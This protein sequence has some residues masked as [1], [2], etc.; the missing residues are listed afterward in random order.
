MTAAPER[1]RVRV[2]PVQEF[3]FQSDTREILANAARDIDTYDLRNRLIVDIDSHHE[4]SLE[5][6][7]V[8]DNLDDQVL[9]DY[10]KGI[11]GSVPGGAEFALTSHAPG[12][13][14]QEIGGRIP[15]SAE[16]NEPVPSGSEHTVAV[17]E[18]A[19]ESLGLDYQV[20]FPQT[21]L[22]L[23]LHPVDGIAVAL[24]MAYNKWFVGTV[25]G[26]DPRI[27]SMLSLPISDPD[28][29][30][31]TIRLYHDHPDVLGFLITSQRSFGVHDNQNMPVYAELE[32]V[33]LPLGFHAG[34]NWGDSW[35]RTMN[36][37]TTVHAMS[38]VTCNMAHLSN[39]LFNGL[40]ER[41]PRLKVIWIESGLAW[42]PFLMQRLDHEFLL[43]TSD[44]PLLTKRPS[45]YMRQMYYTSQPLEVS[46]PKALAQTL[47]MIDAGNTLLYSSD[48]PH[49]DFD[50][51]GRIMTIDGLSETARDNILGRNAQLLFGTHKLPDPA[52]LKLAGPQWRGFG[53]RP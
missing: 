44:A 15:H 32:R 42:V 16:R 23:G 38:F 9:R 37:F 52:H 25:L 17:T 27:K 41:F 4:E 48:W 1:Q 13:R 8:L 34:P 20:V 12:L 19:I 14:F 50:P 39:W 11:A 51:P 22:D 10:G 26:K 3:G 46:H 35:T 53:P 24:T 36:R 43:R 7:E 18:R 47:E 33:G 29:A 30:V 31:E 40:P 49:W 5:W 28:A 21:M 6:S 45:E 2:N